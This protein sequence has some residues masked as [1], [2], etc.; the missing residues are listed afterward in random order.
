MR[1][2]FATP[3]ERVTMQR[4]VPVVDGGSAPFW[5]GCR[6]HKLLAQKCDACGRWRW[7]VAAVCPHCRK[8]G[9]TWTVN[10]GDQ[11]CGSFGDND[12]AVLR[13][14]RRRVIERFRSADLCRG[15]RDVGTLVHNDRDV[16]GAQ[17]SASRIFNWPRPPAGTL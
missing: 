6:A 1:R 4:P 17:V 15:G 5:D 11:R 14:A 9:G 3:A 8:L 12:H 13:R 2:E 16:A 10:G 7:P